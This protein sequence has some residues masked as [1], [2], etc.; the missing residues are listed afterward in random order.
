MDQYTDNYYMQRCLTLAQHGQGRVAPNP[1]V[2]ALVVE[3][4]E[5]IGEGYHQK[6]GQAHAEVNAIAAVK[7]KSRLKNSTIYVNLEPCSHY[8]K[9]PPCS[10]LIIRQQIPRAVIACRDSFEQVD[11]RGIAQ[12]Q[13][14]GCKVKLNV[15]EQE[16]REL[17]RRFFTFHQ[18]QRPY[19]ILK[20]AQTLDG[21]L[22]AIRSQT[23]PIGPLWISNEE[24]R[25]LV[26]KWRSR[27]AA[28]LVGRR[29]A[30]KDNPSLTVRDWHG[31]NPLRIVI[32]KNLS[33]S[34]NLSLFDQSTPTLVIT[35]QQQ[36]R[37]GLVDYL[38]LD[39]EQPILPP[40]LSYLY[41]ASIQSLIVEGGAYLHQSF[42][43]E[44]L[45]DEA[46]VFIGNR[47]FHAGLKAANF[48]KVPALIAEQ[49][50][51]DTRLFTYRNVGH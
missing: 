14:A 20:W 21:F 43:D 35:A 29:T 22:D 23:S 26:H 24:A 30:Q 28:I 10:Q 38:T 42:I 32:D 17:N 48:K 12:L 3:G 27:E 19:I 34:Q 11:G 7:D 37:S 45:W 6:Y 13:A 39:F 1:M 40:L 41:E 51:G 4:N 33:L 9:T 36:K 47:L 18:K 31:K 8:G 50:L 16:A 2:G 44:D 15:L 46:R 49:E 25:L 5:I